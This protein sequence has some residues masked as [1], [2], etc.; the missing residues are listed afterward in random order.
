M[1]AFDLDIFGMHPLPL[2][3][4]VEPAGYQE[5]A[6]RK[7]M[8]QAD[9][10]RFVPETTSIAQSLFYS[11]PQRDKWG[12]Q[13]VTKSGSRQW[14]TEIRGK[15][16][17]ARDKRTRPG[18]PLIADDILKCLTRPDV[19]AH[20]RTDAHVEEVEF[21]RY[22]A[23]AFHTTLVTCLCLDIDMDVAW[24]HKD[25]GLVHHEIARE[26]EI[27]RALGLPYRVFRTGGRGHQLVLPLPAAIDRSAA[28]WLLRG[29]IKILETYHLS[30]ASD[31]GG[32]RLAKAD[33]SNLDAIVR[34]AG[35]RHVTTERLALWINPATGDLYDVP[36]Q[37]GLM[38]RGYRHPGGGPID[39]GDFIEAAEEIA[40]YLQSKMVLRHEAPRSPF[41]ETMFGWVVKALPDN[42]LVDWYRNA[43]GEWGLP[44][45]P[46]P[47]YR[48][49]SGSRG[50]AENRADSL[51]KEEWQ[52]AP[53][54][55]KEWAE[56]VWAFQ[57]GEGTF[58]DWVHEGGQRGLTAA[59][60]LFGEQALT[61]L[62]ERTDSAPYKTPNEPKEW[63][64]VINALYR[65]H[66]ML[67]FKARL[68]PHTV[69]GSLTDDEAA[70]IPGIMDDLYA[71]K[72]IQARNRADMEHIIYV[73]LLA[74]RQS[75]GGFID[76]SQAA[77][78]DSIQARWPGAEIDGST[79]WR[80]L[81]RLKDGDPACGF[82]LLQEI[83]MDRAG[84]N[85]STRYR[86]GPDLRY[87]AFGATLTV[88][89]CQDAPE[90]A[91]GPLEMEVR[92]AVTGKT[93][94]IDLTPKRRG[95]RP[96]Q[97]EQ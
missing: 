72:K 5:I 51:S 65:R 85:P 14:V 31:N 44:E 83:R 11:L 80:H 6:W 88:D 81:H 57:W 3:G 50:K 30:D 20:G 23:E 74:F 33:V 55:I 2:A 49:K 95:R 21:P 70:I 47:L 53:E 67:G 79:I 61:K 46:K 68:N 60:I 66:E 48:G 91:P 71:H 43:Q 22:T 19:Y 40:A 77:I 18:R 10:E 26:R 25:S 94:T 28:T 76:L 87:T 38:R 27:A 32:Q 54:G 64:R 84:Q 17:L 42:L 96:K 58:W 69:I 63:C 34:L 9:Y 15:S 35:G 92:S 4:Y 8:A 89:Q 29:F 86:P 56:R 41:R 75:A 97:Q 1:E 45:T 78:R 36:D 59:K 90:R 24:K 37:I 7:R 39:E 16:Y 62:I 82:S 73:L 93:E 12:K 52:E 13:V